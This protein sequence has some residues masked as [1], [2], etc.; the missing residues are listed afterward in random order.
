[1]LVALLPEQVSDMWPIL[2]GHIDDSLPPTAD[3]GQ[4]DMNT[5]LFNILA[6]YAQIWLYKNKEQENQGFVTTTILNDISGVKTLLIYNMIVIDK[7]AKV[8]WLA[9]LNTLKDFAHSRGC[10]KIGSYVMNP[11]ILEIVKEHEVETRF[12]FAH[13]NI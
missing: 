8:D 3:W 2:K 12:V 4:Y 6:G 9:E 11:K 5:V 10:S 7:S 13:M 1:M